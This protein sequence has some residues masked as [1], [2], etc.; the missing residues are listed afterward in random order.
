MWYTVGKRGIAYM[1]KE[2]QKLKPDIVLKN[3]WSNEERFADLFNAVLFRGEQIIKP[4]ELEDID[5]EESSIF[6][7]KEYVESIKASRDIVK[8]GKVSNTRQM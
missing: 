4:E 6:E 5:A 7:H 3:Y 8:V 1:A 2:K